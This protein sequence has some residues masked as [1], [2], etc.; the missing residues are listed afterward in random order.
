M[1]ATQTRLLDAN[2]DFPVDLWRP[3]LGGGWEDP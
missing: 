1:H 3:L 2:L